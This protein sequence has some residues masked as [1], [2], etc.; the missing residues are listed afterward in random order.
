M[1]DVI[2]R[3]ER[4]GAGSASGVALPLEA[5]GFGDLFVAGG[6]VPRYAEMARRGNGYAVMATGAVAALVAVPSTT[7][8]L[9]IQ[10]ATPGKV[11][12]IDRIFSHHLVS[13]TTGLGSGSV[14]YAMVTRPVAALITD[15]ALV[16]ASLS[17]KAP[18]GK[19]VLTAASSTV[20]ANG[21]FPYG[22]THIKESAGAVVPMGGLEALIEG[23]LMVP[24]MSSLCLHVVS[25][26]TGDTFTSG[27]AFYFEDEDLLRAV[28]N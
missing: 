17:G 24:Y 25:G 23:R 3:A 16:V 20:V 28:R 5:N 22:E 27:A 11:L 10:N 26:Y 21:W 12:I 14:L 15:A 8:A 13:S 7:A 9:E 6:A 18:L 1:T 4:R 19:N 2:V